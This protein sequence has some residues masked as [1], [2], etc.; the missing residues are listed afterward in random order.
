MQASDEK[1]AGDQ[2]PADQAA[3][4][5]AVAKVSS[6]EGEQSGAVLA[7]L[8]KKM[9][10]ALSE[11]ERA[12][13]LSKYPNPRY[14]L[15]WFLFLGSADA[16]IED[17]LKTAVVAPKVPPER[18]DRL[19]S[20]NWHWWLLDNLIAIELSSS[21]LVDKTCDAAGWQLYEQ[22]IAMIHH[23]RKKLAL[24]GVVISVAVSS[25]IGQ[26][27]ALAE[28][29]RILRDH[30]DEIYA[31]M[32]LNC[33]IYLVVTGLDQL[34]GHDGLFRAL[35]PELGKQVIGYRIDP[36]Q[37]MPKAVMRLPQIFDELCTQ[38]EALRL[39]ILEE[40]VEEG[41]GQAGLTSRRRHS[42]EFIEAFKDLGRNIN[43]FGSAML[44][45]DRFR[46]T[47]LW[48]G[49]YFT[50]PRSP[51]SHTQDLFDRFLPVDA[52]VASFR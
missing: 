43:A 34:P 42:Y 41:T 17:L 2:A 4:A 21:F 20:V 23:E 39:G 52:S 31:T 47:L 16:Q 12:P 1:P 8:E 28:R 13:A 9:L 30:L 19:S 3:L 46:H 15:P 49:L 25:M 44:S 38:L 5:W 26:D 48:R 24:N 51:M 11:I 18:A 37:L 35:P 10:Q 14:A 6:S 27:A 40:T 45:D 22:A 29:G 33:P 36:P 7:F 50:A 32:R